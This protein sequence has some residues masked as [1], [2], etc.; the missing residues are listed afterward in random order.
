MIRHQDS[1]G[2]F[3]GGPCF[4]M[5]VRMSFDAFF[6][7][8]ALVLHELVP[9]YRMRNYSNDDNPV[10]EPS[11]LSKPELWSPLQRGLNVHTA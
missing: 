1:G 9:S 8:A 6:F 11:V 10:V 4:R 7:R 2:K 3:V 5:L